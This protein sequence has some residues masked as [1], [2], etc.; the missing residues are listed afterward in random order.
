MHKHWQQ[1]LKKGY[2]MVWKLKQGELLCCG[3]WEKVFLRN[4]DWIELEVENFK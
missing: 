1:G 2:M 4:T 3:D